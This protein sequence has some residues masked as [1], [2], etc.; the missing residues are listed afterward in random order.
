MS[1]SYVFIISFK[2]AALKGPVHTLLWDMGP[3]DLA[4]RKVVKDMMGIDLKKLVVMD[5]KMSDSFL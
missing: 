3:L 2:V 1:S 5:V 4:P